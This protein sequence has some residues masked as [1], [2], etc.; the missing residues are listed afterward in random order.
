MLTLEKLTASEKFRDKEEKSP[1]VVVIQY[2][3]DLLVC[4]PCC[5][6]YIRQ[7]P[8]SCEEVDIGILGGTQGGTQADWGSRRG[9]GYAGREV[10]G[11]K[12]LKKKVNLKQNQE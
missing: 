1:A 10:N 11:E 9:R 4:S 2:F 8:R 6:L 7:E 3:E 12:Q 5:R